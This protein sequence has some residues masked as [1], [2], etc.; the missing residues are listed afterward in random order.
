MG[1]YIKIIKGKLFVY[2]GSR[3][4]TFFLQFIK[5]IS[6]AA[7]L[8]PYYF[9]IWGFITLILQYLNYS[10]FGIHSSLNVLLSTN[11][12]TDVKDASVIVS[13]SIQITFFISAVLVLLSIIP[14]LFNIKIFPKYSFNNYIFFVVVIAILNHFNY[15]FINLY[16]SYGYLIKI[17]ISQFLL[18]AALLPFIFIFK[19][20]MLIY[21]LFISDD[22]N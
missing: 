17:A 1:N 14:F 8:G 9:G 7:V 16:R 4:I 5:T 10:N 11:E 13:S 21:S 3:Y 2:I 6:I 19:D 18:S 22:L 20:E 15:L 12:K